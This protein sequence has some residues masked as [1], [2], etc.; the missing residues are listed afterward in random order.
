M[1]GT[2][3]LDLARIMMVTSETSLTGSGIIG[4]AKGK[5]IT[6]LTESGVEGC[7][8]HV[9][10]KTSWKLLTGPDTWKKPTKQEIAEERRGSFEKILCCC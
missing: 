7:P 4:K 8:Y 1:K 9:D 2:T 10:F 6:K 5:G 3:Y